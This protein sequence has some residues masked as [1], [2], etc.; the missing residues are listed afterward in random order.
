[1]EVASESGN[2]VTHQSV[3]LQA[4]KQTPSV[5]ENDG[6]EIAVV[7]N[8]A[9]E[10]ENGNVLTQQPVELEA[11]KQTPIVNENDKQA[12]TSESFNLVVLSEQQ[13]VEIKESSKQTPCMPGVNKSDVGESAVDAKKAISTE[14]INVLIS[15]GQQVE[16]EASNQK[17]GNGSDDGEIIVDQRTSVA[18]ESFNVVT[19]ERQQLEIEASYQSSG[20][21]ESGGRAG[22]VDQREAV[23]SAESFNVVTSELQQ[24]EIDAHKQTACVNENDVGETVVDPGEAVLTESITVGTSD[25]Q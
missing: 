23:A 2:V 10:S 17:T 15:A 4:N 22:G 11:N 25:G 20:V 21:N 1:E 12:V 14:G 3:E 7:Q 9:V 18:S 13:Q 24:V 6:E 16:I 19:S 5:K 8:K